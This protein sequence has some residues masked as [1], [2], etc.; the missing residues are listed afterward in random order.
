[1]A[2]ITISIPDDMM[3][4][5]KE[6]TDVNWSAVARE[7]IISYIQVRKNPGIT[8]QTFNKL[9]QQKNEEYVRGIKDA[10]KLADELGYKRL[11]LLVEE[12]KNQID[13]VDPEVIMPP[14][15]Y[16]KTFKKIL[17]EKTNVA[18]DSTIDYTNG[19]RDQIIKMYEQL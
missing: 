2:K 15:D 7:N 9:R 8:S 12:Y 10:D 17:V 16:D 3:K 19:I 11:A 18:D 6:M 14:V 5:L 4:D 1:M 13:Y